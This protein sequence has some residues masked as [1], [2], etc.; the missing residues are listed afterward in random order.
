MAACYHR[1][2]KFTDPV[3]G[4]LRGAEIGAMWKMLLEISQGGLKIHFRDADAHLGM[5]KAHWDAD[6]TFSA[7]GLP[8]HNSIDAEFEIREGLIYRHQ[9]HFSLHRWSSQALGL[10]GFLF[11]NTSFLQ[12]ALRQQVREKL[13]LWMQAHP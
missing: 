6:Y 8:V 11:G 1:D 9:D 7:T 4:T 5:G 10:P 12:N 13:K 2:A 3:F